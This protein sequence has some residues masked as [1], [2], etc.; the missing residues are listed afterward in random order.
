VKYAHFYCSI[1]A[2]FI[3]LR[4]KIWDYYTARLVKTIEPNFDTKAST[5]PCYLVM[6]SINCF[7]FFAGLLT[8]VDEWKSIGG[9]RSSD[10]Q[11]G[12]H[13]RSKRNGVFCL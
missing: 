6:I 2:L 7:L 4:P 11:C 12:S 10:Q 8:S 1:T 13:W 5:W 9:R 3:S